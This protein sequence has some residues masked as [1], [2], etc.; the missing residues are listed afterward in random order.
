MR[1]GVFIDGGYFE[2]I[3]KNEFGEVPID[4]SKLIAVL[5]EG[6]ELLRTYY[7]NCLPY[8]SSPPTEEESQRF[9]RKER[10]FSYLRRLPRFCVRLGKLAY[11][12]MT[13]D[14]KK[15]F[16]QKGIDT[17]LSIDMVNLAATK[18]VSNIILLAGDSDYIPAVEVVKSHGVGVILYHSQKK[19]SYHVDLWQTCDERFPINQ[20]L[21]NKIRIPSP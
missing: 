16:E 12:G 17:L 8:Q 6:R 3:I 21:I 2:K 5:V 14:G 7:Y 18:Q 20:S 9:A 15:I 13:N 1:T 19:D 4:F 11:R 10:F